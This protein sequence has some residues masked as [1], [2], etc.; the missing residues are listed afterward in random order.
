MPKMTLTEF[1]ADLQIRLDRADIHLE[2]ALFA[3][4]RLGDYDDRNA[5]D[6][7]TF[8]R[9]AQKDI[10]QVSRLL[11]SLDSVKQISVTVTVAKEYTHR[12]A[13]RLLADAQHDI[14][15]ALDS[16]N[17]YLQDALYKIGK[18]KKLITEKN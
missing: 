15:D 6:A 14:R 11:D 8:C 5:N 18:A 9:E 1:K 16:E 4:E 13:L 12:D 7:D 2:N 17:P 3:V 10:R